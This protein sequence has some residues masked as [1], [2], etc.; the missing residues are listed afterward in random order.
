MGGE[1]VGGDD[2]QLY[3]LNFLLCP[4]F[5]PSANVVALGGF[6]IVVGGDESESVSDSWDASILG[7][8]TSKWTG[9]GDVLA[10]TNGSSSNAKESFAIFSGVSFRDP[11]KKPIQLDTEPSTKET[12]LAYGLQF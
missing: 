2:S 6:L 12:I 7:L 1:V 11:S 5:L 3:K 4:S 8:G 10:G 9:L